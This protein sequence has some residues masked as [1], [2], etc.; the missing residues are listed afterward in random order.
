MIPETNVKDLML[1]KDVVE[2]V[3]KDKFHVYAVK[4]IDEGIEILTGKAAGE[5][6]A[7]GSYPKGTV[8]DLVNE[9]LKNLAVGLSKFGKNN[10]NKQSKNS[11]EKKPCKKNK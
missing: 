4:T 6:K 2:A 10:N 1:R 7:D 9:K 5:V 8:N 11:K 3:K